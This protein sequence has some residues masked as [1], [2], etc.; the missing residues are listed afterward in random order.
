MTSITRTTELDLPPLDELRIE[1]L[2]EGYR[3]IDRLCDEWA[4]GS[5][6]FSAPGEALFLDLLTIG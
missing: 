6:R 2:R 4:S 3:F 1:S 5:N